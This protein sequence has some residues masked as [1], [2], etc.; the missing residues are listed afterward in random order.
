MR[1]DAFDYHLPEE[2]IAQ[3]P[4][5]RR[6]A[7]RLLVIGERLQ[8]A[9]FFELPNFL[10]PGDALVVND[11]RV[12]PARLIGERVPSGG[13]VELLLLRRLAADRWEVLAGPA[14]KARAD[15][16]L[17]FGA[18]ALSARVTAERDEGR[19][20]VAF[21]WD[22][23]TGPFEALLERLGQMP[24]PPYIRSRLDDPSRYQTVYAQEPGSAAAP[25]AGLHFTPELLE[26]LQALGVHVVPITLHVGLG[27]F[28]PVS[29]EEI[30]AHRMH[31]EYYRVDKAA[32]EALARVR[33]GGGRI[34]AVGTTACRALESASRS[35]ELQPTEGWT[36]IFIYP[37][38]RFRAIDGLITNFHLPK[39][40]LLMLV[41][42]LGGAER[43]RRA[44][45]SAVAE[46]YR[47]FSF[48]DAMLIWPPAGR[49]G[50]AP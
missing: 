27:T 49:E 12:L 22:P 2:L 33:A 7:S 44:Y 29:A 8:H 26:R 19:R 31:A 1:T 30:E 35:G 15:Q 36:D 18:G 23:S 13:K 21:T 50:V 42:A 11:S 34:V 32:A 6:D 45:E 39:S 43:M 46:R 40:T 17:S 3:T 20:E 24:L 41:Y 28:R 38:Y 48:G 5:A 37:G 14:R 10:R 25:T 4:L 9:R 47:F 16:E